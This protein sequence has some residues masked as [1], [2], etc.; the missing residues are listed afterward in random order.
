M[1]IAIDLDEVLGEFVQEFLKW[2]N[3]CYGTNWTFND[4]VDYHWPNF[5]HTSVGQIIDD[6][7][8]FFATEEFVNL[9]LVSGARAGVL[10]LAKTHRLCVVTGRPFVVRNI[11]RQ[12]LDCN[13][14]GVF[15]TVEFTN[16]YA[17]DMVPVCS[18]GELCRKLQ[19]DVLIDDDIRH[20]GSLLQ[21]GVRPVILNKPWNICHPLPAAVARADSWP[22][23]VQAVRELS[24]STIEQLSNGITVK[25]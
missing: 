25:V 10:E 15:E 6:A 22:E 13:F 19:C 4:V 23:I 21:H 24:N 3:R 17:K 11:T 1:K 2:Y 20:V 18:K 5:M 14:P 12:W 7:H 9:P 8:R 16:N